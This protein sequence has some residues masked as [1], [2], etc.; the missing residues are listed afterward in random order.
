[1]KLLI[2]DYWEQLWFRLRFGPRVTTDLPVTP[3]DYRDR[4]SVVTWL[5]VFGLGVSLLSDLPTLVFRLNALGS[6]ISL[7]FN[8]TAVAAT[9]LA[10][11][12]AAG[13][14]SV[15]SVYPRLW[16]SQ[17]WRR[18]HNWPFWA[19]PMAL[20]NILAVLLPRAPTPL[21]QVLG[22]LIVSGL[23]ILAFFAL[24]YTVEPGQPG[25]RRARLALN[26]LT[27]GSALVLFLFVYQARTRSLVSG[28]LVALTSILLAIELL[29]TSTN[30]TSTV[31][32]YGMIVGLIL[33]QVTWALNYWPLPD[34]TGGLLLLLIFYLLVGIAQHGLQG[35]LTRRV[36]VEFAIFAVVALLLIATVGPGFTIQ[37]P[38]PP[39]DV[40]SPLP[41]AVG[42]GAFSPHSES[43]SA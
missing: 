12:A 21:I 31:I 27:Y 15:V 37:R 10:V 36:L 38:A 3:I 13:A 8:N 4:I 40:Q 11:L 14:E 34:L 33:G 24:Y 19:L 23:L 5:L 39:P 25:F 32:A 9:F 30:R 26:I 22:L 35:R 2:Q 16:Q 17:G 18:Q 20:T 29:R 7:S 43:A 41:P 28:S 6:P 42:H 1:M